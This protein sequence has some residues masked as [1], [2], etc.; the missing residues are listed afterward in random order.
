MKKYVGKILVVM[1]SMII[2]FF[3]LQVLA[4]CIPQRLMKEEAI[5]SS[6]VLDEEG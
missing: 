4:F 1:L 3:C 5:E 2:L 6:E